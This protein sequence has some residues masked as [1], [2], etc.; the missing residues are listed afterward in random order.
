MQSVFQDAQSLSPKAWWIN[1]WKYY[2]K[3]L[4]IAGFVCF[5]L[6][7]GLGLFFIEA[8]VPAFEFSLPVV[9]S[10]F[11]FYIGMMGIANLL[12]FLGPLA[13]KLLNKSGNHFFRRYIFRMGYIFSVSLPF[14][15]L[16]LILLDYSRM[17]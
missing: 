5:L 12:F 15:M 6:Y 9:L 10:Q 17:R 3:S 13:D 11:G 4:A 7:Y 2:N 8:Y 1:R 14:A 16:L